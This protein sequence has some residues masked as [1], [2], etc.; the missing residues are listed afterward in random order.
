[1]KYFYRV[2]CTLALWLTLL[3]ARADNLTFSK[4]LNYW[5]DPYGHTP[6]VMVAHSTWID[7][8]FWSFL[9]GDYVYAPVGV[10]SGTT[11]DVGTFTTPWP[12]GGFGFASQMEY[13]LLPTCGLHTTTNWKAFSFTMSMQLNSDTPITTEYGTFFEP[14][15]MNHVYGGL[16]DTWSSWSATE[17]TNHNFISFGW[18]LN[19]QT[20]RPYDQDVIDAAISGYPWKTRIDW[21]SYNK[22]V[23]VSCNTNEVGNWG[24]IYTNNG[25]PLQYRTNWVLATTFQFT[26]NYDAQVSF[27]NW[28]MPPDQGFFLIETT[29]APYIPPE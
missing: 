26:T 5:N 23:G 13:K 27:T 19:I 21:N 7:T 10:S 14:A 12:Y 18:S 20:R 16:F 17:D 2:F 6:S 15:T 22:L 25:G 9:L 29:N 8:W 28:A 24:W 4:T 11:L 1:M 3:P